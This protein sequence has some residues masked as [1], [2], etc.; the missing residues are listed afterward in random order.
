MVTSPRWKQTYE[1]PQALYDSTFSVCLHPRSLF[2]IY[3]FMF[4]RIGFGWILKVNA[5]SFPQQHIFRSHTWP[6]DDV[7]RREHVNDIIYWF[8]IRDYLFIDPCRC[9]WERSGCDEPQSQSI[10]NVVDEQM[11]LQPA[12][13]DVSQVSVVPFSLRSFGLNR[14]VCSTFQTCFCSYDETEAV[15]EESAACSGT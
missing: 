5:T 3:R 6:A 4:G 2:I 7:G 13:P 11:N 10:I 14:R 9:R 1:G 15:F 8:I 12:H